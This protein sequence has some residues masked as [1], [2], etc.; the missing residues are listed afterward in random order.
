[1]WLADLSAISFL[2]FKI[3]E[4]SALW[5]RSEVGYRATLSRWRSRVRTPPE[6]PLLGICP[7]CE[8]ISGLS[9]IEIE[10]TDLW[11]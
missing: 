2:S 9:L 11:V 3:A 1:M 6:S 8:K 4:Q 5:L 7:K 10:W